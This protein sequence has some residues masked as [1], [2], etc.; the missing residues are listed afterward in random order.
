L[1]PCKL[2]EEGK[3]RGNSWAEVEKG[4]KA[5]LKDQSR[6]EK[7]ALAALWFEEELGNKLIL[8]ARSCWQGF[9]LK[10]VN[11]ADE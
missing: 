2:A 4:E 11:E 9:H 7:R 10:L 5:E 3:K 8:G 6:E 1:D